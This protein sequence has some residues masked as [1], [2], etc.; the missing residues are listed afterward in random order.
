MFV[1]SSW[2]QLTD[3]R[4]PNAASLIVMLASYKISAVG[5]LA[6]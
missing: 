5:L 4:E 2:Q 3:I 6:C 1:A